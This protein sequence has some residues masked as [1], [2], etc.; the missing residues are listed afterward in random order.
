MVKPASLQFGQGRH[1]CYL[2]SGME[3][4]ADIISKQ[5][6]ALEFMFRKARLITDL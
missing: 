4:K 2:Q 3:V 6:T 5:E 1:Q